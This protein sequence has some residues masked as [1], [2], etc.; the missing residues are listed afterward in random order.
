MNSYARGPDVCLRYDIIENKAICIIIISDHFAWLISF[1][2][3]YQ[4][5][6]GEVKREYVHCDSPFE[7]IGIL[8]YGKETEW[9]DRS[10]SYHD[11]YSNL[12]TVGLS[13][14]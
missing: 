5:F 9:L 6:A 12:S 7:I 10:I 1:F 14:R 13:A 11:P 8:P 4:S 3:F 2:T